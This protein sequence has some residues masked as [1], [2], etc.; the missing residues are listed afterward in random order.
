ME[1][2]ALAGSSESSVPSL[3]PSLLCPCTPA[4]LEGQPSLAL[5]PSLPSI[6]VLGLSSSSPANSDM[7]AEVVE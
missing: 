1:D 2:L 7:C 5:V 3:C 6:A 4:W